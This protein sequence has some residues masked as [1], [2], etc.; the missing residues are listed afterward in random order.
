MVH[1]VL[2]FLMSPDF[3]RS[4]VYVDADDDDDE[5]NDDISDDEVE[6]NGED[7]SNLDE[8]LLF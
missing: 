5:D 4:Y 6:D 2:P 1:N 3:V 8:E 7:D